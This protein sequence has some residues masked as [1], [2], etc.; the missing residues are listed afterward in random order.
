MTVA[1][2]NLLVQVTGA[3]VKYSLSKII[4]QFYKNLYIDKNNS[5]F[6]PS[7]F[8]KRGYA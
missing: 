2:C 7:F 1:I 6:D 5:S 8:K 4:N 3:L